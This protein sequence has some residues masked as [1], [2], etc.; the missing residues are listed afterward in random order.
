M[1]SRRPLPG[2]SSPEP[3][4][5]QLSGP[6]CCAVP[7]L[8]T[9]GNGKWPRLFGMLPPPLHG[10]GRPDTF[11]LV[12]CFTGLAPQAFLGFLFFSS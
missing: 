8:D 7:C 4:R 10:C 12:I 9:V 5:V 1:G 6:G 3:E 11:P 2:L